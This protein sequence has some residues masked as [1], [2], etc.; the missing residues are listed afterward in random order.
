MSVPTTAKHVL[1]QRAKQLLSQDRSVLNFAHYTPSQSHLERM[2]ILAKQVPELYDNPE[3]TPRS[4]WFHH[5]QYRQNS[6]MPPFHVHF[7][8]ELQ[9]VIQYLV[10]AVDAQEDETNNNSRSIVH[11]FQ[12]AHHLFR[13][14][15]RGLHGHVSIEEYACFPLYKENFPQVDISCLVEDHKDLHASER[16]VEKA[17][18]QLASHHGRPKEEEKQDDDIVMST[19][20]LVLNFDDQLMT[21]LGEEEEIVVPMSLT[22]K[23]I[24]F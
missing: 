8:Q 12:N 6:Q 4:Q 5:P 14:S 19:L 22:E 16:G 9:R 24:W 18:E 21:H 3:I 11:L 23:P 17:L 15:M 20:T 10:Q 13:S 1:L 2:K 7:R